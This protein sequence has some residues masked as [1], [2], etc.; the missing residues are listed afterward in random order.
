MSV[1][2]FCFF[3]SCVLYIFLDKYLANCVST[4]GK[5]EK[6]CALWYNLPQQMSHFF[7]ELSV[8]VSVGGASNDSAVVSQCSGSDEPAPQPEASPPCPLPS[9]STATAVTLSVVPTTPSWTHL[10]ST[11]HSL[12]FYYSHC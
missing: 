6:V 10:I 3:L 9:K 8:S 1:F 4:I 7:P 12:R 2:F 11:S 5:L